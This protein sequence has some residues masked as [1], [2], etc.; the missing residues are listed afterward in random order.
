MKTFNEWV[1]NEEKKSSKKDDKKLNQSDSN[2]IDAVMDL[3]K[4]IQTV[5]KKYTL[6][7]RKSAWKKLH[8]KKAD[9]LF[10][11]LLVN[12]SRSLNT[13]RN[14]AIDSK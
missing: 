11:K 14:I 7:T 3:A 9:E 1:L 5:F 13:F 8:T 10:E 6:Q 12:P 2:R 4:A